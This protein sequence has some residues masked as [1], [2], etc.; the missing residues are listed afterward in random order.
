[1]GLAT[2][3]LR[4]GLFLGLLAA[5]SSGCFAGLLAGGFFSLLG[6]GFRLRLFL[7]G[8][9]VLFLTF[10]GRRLLFGYFLFRRFLLLTFRRFVFDFF[11]VLVGIVA[12]HCRSVAFI[13]G[14][15]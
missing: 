15:H 8:C 5:S 14:A 6:W 4:G 13:L 1:V 11:A 7:L 2:L 9:V 12:F 10:G 3:F